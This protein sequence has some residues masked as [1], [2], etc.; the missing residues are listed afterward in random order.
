MLLLRYKA[1]RSPH[2]LY[3]RYPSPPSVLPVAQHSVL[4]SALCGG[5][6]CVNM[7]DW[8]PVGSLIAS[9]HGC[10]SVLWSGRVNK[11]WI[12]ERKGEE[13]EGEWWNEEWM[14]R[15]SG[16][17]AQEEK[18]GSASGRDVGVNNWGTEMKW[19][20][21]K[22]EI[23]EV[24]GRQKKR[25]RKEEDE[26]SLLQRQQKPTASHETTQTP[27]RWSA[28]EVCFVMW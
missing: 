8:A 13:G 17:W 16:E 26:K 6:A 23:A 14:E 20:S 22:Y 15:L 12:Q 24:W 7:T 19:T 5:L 28:R 1:S 27:L 10:E 25:K 9:F 21:V 18:R 11:L 2:F 3:H 4:L